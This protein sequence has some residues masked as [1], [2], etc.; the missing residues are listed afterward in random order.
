MAQKP[1]AR[2]VVKPKT[3]V[4]APAPTTTTTTT[5]LQ[6]V[7]SAPE[8]QKSAFDKFYDRLA[9]SYFG[10]FTS[11]VLKKWNSS[12][13]ALSKE[14]GDTG[15]KCH[16]NCDTYAMNLWNQ[17]NFAYD[18]GWKLKFVFIPRW[19]VY[20][21]NPRDMN[22]TVGEDRAMVGLEDFLVGFAGVI[23][24]SSD[25]KFNWF[26]RPAM[27][28]PTSHFTRH[29][30]NGDFG[31][32]TNQVE[33]SHY[34][35]YDLNP[36][37]QLGLQL[38]QRLW[39]FDYRYNPS[40]LRFYTSPYVQYSINEKTRVA[41]YYQS[42]IENNKRWKTVN[43]KSP[44]FKDYYQDVMIAFGRDLT[45]RLSVMPYLGY[46]VDQVPHSMQNAYIGSWIS[47]KIK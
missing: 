6:S 2:K 12:N 25:K 17:V 26:W 45:D 9:I 4:T 37:W 38:Q 28:L 44:V 34:I 40:R 32:I 43:G 39:V 13:A 42:M 19:T 46:F 20:G 22:R 8:V 31:Q 16:L 1:V 23:F 15:K 24:A 41:V 7:G 27:R 30:N 14:W 11:P 21:S 36:Q 33:M 35:T 18:F 47:Y 10:V 3:T 5:S 29:Y